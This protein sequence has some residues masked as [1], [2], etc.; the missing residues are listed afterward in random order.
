M[1]ILNFRTS[2]INKNK[3]KIQANKILLEAKKLKKLKKIQN[4]KNKKV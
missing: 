4:Q 3:F 2:K 1:I